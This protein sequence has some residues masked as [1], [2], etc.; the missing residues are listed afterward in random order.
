MRIY[1]DDAM[2]NEIMSMPTDDDLQE[3]KVGNLEYMGF[4]TDHGHSWS[5][6]GQA[7]NVLLEE[8]V[9]MNHFSSRR[10]ER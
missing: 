7:Y 6:D 5:R 2:I 4:D 8:D 1:E 10:I 9:Y 3:Y